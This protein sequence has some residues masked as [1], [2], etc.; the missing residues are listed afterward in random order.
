ME[1]RAC[2]AKPSMRAP[3]LELLCTRAFPIQRR[4]GIKILGPFPHQDDGTFV[5]LRGF[6]DEASRTT[7]K[8]AFYEG[9]DWLNDPQAQAEQMLDDYDAVV[10]EE[11]VWKLMSCRPV[12]CLGPR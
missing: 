6:P 10:V 5:W 12:W 4:L 2:R 8:A 3:L 11:G 7:L 9:P 1:I